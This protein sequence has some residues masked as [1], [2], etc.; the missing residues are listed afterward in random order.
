L[1]ALKKTK[2]KQPPFQEKDNSHFA[3]II[4]NIC[5]PGLARITS[6]GLRATDNRYKTKSVSSEEEGPVRLSHGGG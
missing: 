4:S 1:H 3:K 2:E 6:P 5:K